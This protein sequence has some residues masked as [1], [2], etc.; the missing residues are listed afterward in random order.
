MPVH[1]RRIESADPQV[2]GQ[3]IIRDPPPPNTPLAPEFPATAGGT[4]GIALATKQDSALCLCITGALNPGTHRLSANRSSETP[5]PP[6]GPAFPASAGGTHCL[7]L[8][9]PCCS[10]KQDS[11]VSPHLVGP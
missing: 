10:L 5:L 11:A 3:Q 9:C 2:F 4:E 1:H 8:P 6:R 7:A